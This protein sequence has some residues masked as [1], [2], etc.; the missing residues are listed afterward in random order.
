MTLIEAE[1]ASLEMVNRLADMLAAL[2]VNAPPAARE[3]IESARDAMNRAADAF[4]DAG[5]A[6]SH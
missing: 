1:A 6:R 2:P 5:E 3:A 4:A